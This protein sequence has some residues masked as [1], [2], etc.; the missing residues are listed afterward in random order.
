MRFNEDVYEVFRLITYGRVTS[1]GAI[2][3]YLLDTR[4]SRLVGWAL[5]S[6]FSIETEVPEHM[7]C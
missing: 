6:S 2:A 7:R 5:N 4:A 3:R 1:Y